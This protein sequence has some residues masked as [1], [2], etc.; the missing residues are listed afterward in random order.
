VHFRPYLL[1]LTTAA[2]LALFSGVRVL[3]RRRP[4]V[5]PRQRATALDWAVT[6][7]ALAIGGWLLH[8]SL[9]GDVA[10]PIAVVRVTAYSVLAYAI[11]DVYRFARPHGFPFSPHLWLYEHLVKLIGAYFG[12]VA[13][14]SGAVLTQ[15]PDP[16]RQ[17]GPTIVGQTLMIVL[18]VHYVRRV[19]RRDADA[20]ARARTAA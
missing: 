5:D 13:A 15:I 10:G 17:L 12:A 18:L 20:R 8:R 14:F 4:D 2:T 3:R 16:W 6:L 11:Y 19:R 9:T 1:A 7:T